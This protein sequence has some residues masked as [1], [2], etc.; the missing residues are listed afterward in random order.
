MSDNAPYAKLQKRI[1]RDA[2]WRKLTADAQRMYWLLCSQETR[3]LAGVVPLTVRKWANY[4]ADTTEDSVR[5]ALNEFV[6]AQ[7]IV[8]DWDTEE[9][10]IRTFIRNARDDKS[11]N[12]VNAANDG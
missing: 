8:V 12:M 3:S 2:D 10:L 11:R 4:A 1:W 7:F 9:V 6:G 5:A